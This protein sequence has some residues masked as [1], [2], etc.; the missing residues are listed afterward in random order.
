MSQPLQKEAI[1]PF[2]AKPT[3]EAAPAPA[4]QSGAESPGSEVY[5]PRNESPM[6]RYYRNKKQKLQQQ[7]NALQE[8]LKANPQDEATREQLRKL[9]DQEEQARHYHGNARRHSEPQISQGPI[10]QGLATPTMARNWYQRQK[11]AQ[12]V[13]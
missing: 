4:P 10:L 5:T 2:K 13:V 1:W 9:W 6:A 8:K 11:V 7:I 12:R 3:P